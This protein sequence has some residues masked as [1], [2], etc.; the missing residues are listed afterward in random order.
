MAIADELRQLPGNDACAHC[1]DSDPTWA[2]VSLGLL[3]CLKCSGVHRGLGV[4]ISFVRSVTLDQWSSQQIAMMKAG[5]NASFLETCPD[6]DYFSEE[7]EMYRRTLKASVSGEQAEELTERDK[8]QLAQMKQN[9][10]K[11]QQHF[12]THQDAPSWIP[13]STSPACQQCHQKFTIVRRRHH[14]RHCG[15]L[16]C[17]TCAPQ[18][19][20]KPI[21]K[22]GITKPWL[23][24]VPVISCVSRF[25][26]NINTIDSHNSPWL[27]SF[28]LLYSSLATWHVIPILSHTFDE[29]PFDLGEMLAFTIL[30]ALCG[31][32]AS[33]FVFL[34]R[35]VIETYAI[36]S[37]PGRALAVI[38]RYRY[39]YPL[40]IS[41]FIAT[42]TFPGLIGRHLSLV[43]A[44]EINHL[45]TTERLQCIEE[46][47]GGSLILNLV[48]FVIVKFI[49]TILAITMPIPAG[50]F[51]PVFVIG[52]GFGRLIGESMAIWFPTGLTSGGDDDFQP[53]GFCD[54][55][56]GN[57]IVPGGYAV[58]GAA[59]LAGGVTHT[60]STS[61][62]VFELTGQIHHIL[63]VMVAVLI[64]NAICQTLSPSIYDSIIQIRGLPYLPDIRR[65]AVFQRTVDKFMMKRPPF[66]SLHC[67]YGRI[68]RTLR[69]SAL[70]Y[71]PLV[72]SP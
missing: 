22:F 28:A 72:D 17:S 41:F 42:L 34:H 70:T 57:H 44:T 32:F 68:Y 15:R 59:A 13:D 62:I 18:N 47:R 46:W 19:N 1:G 48:I 56:G 36:Y 69:R 7:A 50:V 27:P 23:W 16:V 11:S 8:K 66:V 2:S 31:V 4:N 6:R 29:Y 58:V 64:A 52:A 30:G 43:Q 35:K 45:F 40:I 51:V 63:P 37:Q 21:P 9:Y 3:L 39:L 12:I 20:T 55:G 10:S 65:D 49:V 14:C 61:V 54:W 24:F 38:A 33:F 25:N 5:G 26:T 60:I 67:T 71:L 53:A